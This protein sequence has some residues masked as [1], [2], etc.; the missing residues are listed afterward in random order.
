M[1]SQEFNLIPKENFV[2]A[3]PKAS[4]VL[5]DP[6]ITVYTKQL[7]LVETK[8]YGR[9]RWKLNTVPSGMKSTGYCWE[10]SHKIIINVEPRT[11]LQKPI[12]KKN[13]ETS[14]VGVK[15]DGF[16]TVDDRETT[17]EA[18][19]FLYNLQQKNVKTTWHWLQTYFRQNRFFP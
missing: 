5:R 3:Q 1:R 13:Y 16:F 19:S 12:L 8:T 7:T 11:A 9:K 10:K 15:E 4:E 6:A 14:D 18:T 17:I 2:E